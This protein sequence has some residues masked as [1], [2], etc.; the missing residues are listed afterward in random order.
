MRERKRE[1]DRERKTESA[2]STGSIDKSRLKRGFQFAYEIF[3]SLIIAHRHRT[4]L[5]TEPRLL[6]VDTT[7]SFVRARQAS[8]TGTETG[9]G[10]Q[11]GPGEP[12]AAAVE[13]V[14]SNASVQALRLSSVIS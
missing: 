8:L 7:R 4:C 5:M 13:P 14:G 9:V 12:A 10:P 2:S 11:L 1:K 3:L 6:W